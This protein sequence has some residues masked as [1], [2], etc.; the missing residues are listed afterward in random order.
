[1]SIGFNHSGD[2]VIATGVRSVSFFKINGNT[3]ESKIGSGWGK[4][5]ADTVLCQTL[6]GQSLFTGTFLGEII[7]WTD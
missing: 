7:S 5:P 4:T 3:I 2:T 1:M 6:A